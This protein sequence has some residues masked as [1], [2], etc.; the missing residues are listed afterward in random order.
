MFFIPIY[1]FHPVRTF[2]A[3]WFMKKKMVLCVCEDVCRSSADRKRED[4]KQYYVHITT[5]VRPRVSLTSICVGKL[6]QTVSSSVCVGLSLHIRTNSRSM[7]PLIRRPLATRP[8]LITPHRTPPP[9]DS[10]LFKQKE[11]KKE[12]FKVFI[13]TNTLKFTT[14]VQSNRRSSLK[15]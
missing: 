12:Q 15:V 8:I 2:C 6:R 5:H 4:R 1:V 14:T 13:G 10:L 3:V 9:P 7:S 11:N